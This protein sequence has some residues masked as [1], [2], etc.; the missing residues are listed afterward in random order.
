M[1]CL[2]NHTFGLSQNT[3]QCRFLGC[4]H[5]KDTFVL[6]FRQ[7]LVISQILRLFKRQ[8]Y[9]WI[10]ALFWEMS[11]IMLLLFPFAYCVY[12]WE[13]PEL[14]LAIILHSINKLKTNAKPKPTV[15]SSQRKQ[16][17]KRKEQEKCL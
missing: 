8:H 17:V 6:Y 4:S 3:L 11:C 10:S 7:Y 14:H 12:L 2:V 1:C 15:Q 13:Q 9:S 5:Q 16:K